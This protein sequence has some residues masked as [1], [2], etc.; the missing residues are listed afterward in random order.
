MMTNINDLPNEILM[1]IFLEV[2]INELNTIMRM[3][4]NIYNIIK[5]EYFF[6]LMLKKHYVRF[7][8]IMLCSTQYENFKKIYKSVDTKIKPKNLN[9]K[10]NGITYIDK[11]LILPY[12]IIATILHLPKLEIMYTEIIAYLRCSNFNFNKVK[13]IYDKSDV[14]RITIFV[15]IKDNTLFQNYIGREK[16]NMSFNQLFDKI[17]P[18]NIK[19]KEHFINTQDMYAITIQIKENNISEIYYSGLNSDRNEVANLFKEVK[20]EYITKYS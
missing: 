7:S 13:D 9:Y 3:N 14:Y 11:T 15:T 18:I 10:I 16:I 5:N 19:D 12:N 20:A 8:N 1:L 17:I 6:K 2:P 4:K